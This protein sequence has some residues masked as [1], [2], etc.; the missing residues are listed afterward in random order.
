SRGNLYTF[1]NVNSEQI[2]LS[3][4]IF[5]KTRIQ[6]SKIFWNE[7]KYQKRIYRTRDHILFL[8]IVKP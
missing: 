2:D 7:K 1:P 6:L 4:Q 8:E 5:H 3:N